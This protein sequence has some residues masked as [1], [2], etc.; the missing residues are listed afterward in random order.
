M[1]E[2]MT[3][4]KSCPLSLP[5]RIRRHD[6]SFPTYEDSQMR[7][8]HKKAPVVSTAGFKIFKPKPWSCLSNLR[9]VNQTHADDYSRY[10]IPDDDDDDDDIPLLTGLT[11]EYP[12]GP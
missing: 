9:K 4:K 6:G 5:S 8:Y 3:R 10:T 12:F 11:R 1:I 2:I 7:M